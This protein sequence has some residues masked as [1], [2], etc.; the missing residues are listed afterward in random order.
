[1]PIS[2][3]LVQSKTLCII[4]RIH[5]SWQIWKSPTSLSRSVW[6]LLRPIIFACLPIKRNRMP[7]G[8]VV[9]WWGSASRRG[10]MQRSSWNPIL[11]YP[12]LSFQSSLRANTS[13]LLR[14]RE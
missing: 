14:S 10:W 11:S 9:N 7:P 3:L 2:Q 6:S 4:H 1:M 5:H 8:H 12:I 13:C